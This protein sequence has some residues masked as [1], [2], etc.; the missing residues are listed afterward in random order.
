[1]KIHLENTCFEKVAFKRE[2]YPAKD[3]PEVCICGRSNVGK[4]SFINATF[5]NNIAK[6]G[7]TPGK[8]RSIV[9]FNVDNIFRIVDLPGY[10]YAKVSKEEKIKWRKMIEDYLNNRQQLKLGI[11]IID[12]RVG[13]TEDDMLMF[14]FL[15]SKEIPIMIVANKCDKLSNNKLAVQRKVISEKLGIS[16]EY[17]FFV[18]S[19]NKLGIKDVQKSLIDFFINEIL[20][21]K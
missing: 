20:G 19:K 15:E 21:E 11:L 17:I 12:I 1:M 9:F 16:P 7:S 5:K 18:S 3:L 10:G 8:T 2:D 14:S 6:V 4:S 13:P